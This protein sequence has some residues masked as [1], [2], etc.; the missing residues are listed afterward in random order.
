VPQSSRT[1]AQEGRRTPFYFGDLRTADE[2]FVGQR[3]WEDVTQEYYND[4]LG[5]FGLYVELDVPGSFFAEEPIPQDRTVI[6]GHGSTIQCIVQFGGRTPG[7]TEG[8]GTTS[9]GWLS[10]TNL[11]DDMSGAVLIEHPKNCDICLMSKKLV[12]FDDQATELYKKHKKGLLK[13]L[14]L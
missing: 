6:L 11:L 4:T 8:F 1:L 9:A 5:E 10:N 2:S 14:E 3:V 13:E 12:G 7:A